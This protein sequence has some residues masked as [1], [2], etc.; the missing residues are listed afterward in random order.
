MRREAT[1]AMGFANQEIGIVNSEKRART[2]KKKKRNHSLRQ[3]NKHVAY[4]CM[5]RNNWQEWTGGVY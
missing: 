5:V 4:Y 1:G 2:K 3:L